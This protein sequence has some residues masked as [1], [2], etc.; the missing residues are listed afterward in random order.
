[1]KYL[2]LLSFFLFVHAGLSGQI[3]QDDQPFSA[4]V[5]LKSARLVAKVEL[6]VN[7]DSLLAEASRIKGTLKTAIYG[8]GIAA[9]VNFL[10]S[11]S[12][13]KVSGGKLYQLSIGAEQATALGLSFSRWELPEGGKLFVWNS[14]RTSYIGAFTHHNNKPWGGMMIRPV[15]GHTLHLEYFEPDHTQT[16]LVIDQL[17][18][19]L[20]KSIYGDHDNSFGLSA[21]CQVD[22]N[23]V[24][25]QGW[26]REKRSVVKVITE[27][28]RHPQG[29][30]W[31]TKYSGALINNTAQDGTPYL[32][33][34]AHCVDDDENAQKSIYFFNY[35][36]IIL[37]Q[38]GNKEQ[39]LVGSQVMATKPGMD[40]TLLKLS[41][42]VPSSYRPYYSG[43]DRNDENLEFAVAIHH[44]Q[45]DVKKISKTFSKVI[46]YATFHNTE[47]NFDKE[48]H[49]EIER[50]NVGVSEGGSSGSPLFNE[51]HRIIGDL[52][53]GAAKCE[54]P[55]GDSYQMFSLAWNSSDAYGQQLKHWLDPLNLDVMA[56]DGYDPNPQ[57]GV[58][59][60]PNR[61]LCYLNEAIT[62][63][64]Y[65]H[66]DYS[67]YRWNFG[68]MAS[69][70]TATGKEPVSV[71]YQAIGTYSASLTVF[72]NTTGQ[73][74]TFQLSD[75]IEVYHRNATPAFKARE[76]VAYL[77][78]TVIIDNHST[79]SNQEYRWSFGQGASPQQLVTYNLD[80][81]KVSYSTTGKK[82]I[83]LEVVNPNGNQNLTKPMYI[84][85]YEKVQAGFSFEERNYYVGDTL[86][87]DG[88]H[89]KG[90]CL[91]TYYVNDI[92]IYKGD[93]SFESIY[94]RNEGEGL[95]Y[96][97][98]SP[99]LIFNEAGI[100][101]IRYRFTAGD[102]NPDDPA[103]SFEKQ[104]QVYEKVDLAINYSQE[105]DE[106]RFYVSGADK[107]K[108]S[109]RWSFEDGQQFSQASCS[110][111]FT[112]SG[113][114][115][116][117]LD[118][119]N[120]KQEVVAQLEQELDV[121]ITSL[122]DISQA[123]I[124]VYP[125][126]VVDY[127]QI[128]LPHTRQGQAMAR[129]FDITGKCVHS[130]VGEKRISTASLA[131]GM[132]VLRL[133]WEEN[134]Y[135]TKIIKK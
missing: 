36:S 69:P 12:V 28:G 88:Q 57:Q 67:N 133:D 66:G 60:H 25:G 100:Y 29:G 2:Y 51:N 125:N 55:T 70:K 47:L 109:Y 112:K 45:G 93:N 5:Q 34:A 105:G 6:K 130:S 52:T 40:F 102:F 79:G 83:T 7:R 84:S 3:S 41:E 81:V 68:E 89:Q 131:P 39:T 63:T 121:I 27:K 53:G 80:S 97:Y 123:S 72:N 14:D 74:E 19:S 108:Y 116:V 75:Y 90:N 132:Y 50:W 8:K 110:Y 94:Y 35:E 31:Y 101:T 56:L 49:W 10:E 119:L 106:Y 17:I 11:A 37:G 126:P 22:I 87:V 96:Y 82:S 62:F 21:S 134:A 128:E 135:S 1:M 76:T 48:S 33:T 44:P 114:F 59:M 95:K 54:N 65:S 117:L 13:S 42:A 15:E 77:N 91:G 120:E 18:Y 92:S 113:A 118:V 23:D 20:E 58:Y 43:W 124:K 122:N 127:V 38:D 4:R 61:E 115:L 46:A 98:D 104:V 107:S 16:E 32:L 85:V 129:L 9:P 71:T 26:Q 73:D 111:T 30:G 24:A 78:E 86:K 103:I 64:D 99:W